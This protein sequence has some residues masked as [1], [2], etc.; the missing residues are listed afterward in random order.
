MIWLWLW[1]ST[2]WANCTI[3]DLEGALDGLDRALSADFRA[4]QPA[5][6]AVE[7][8][9]KCTKETISAMLAARIHHTFAV[10][11]HRTKD[12]EQ[13]AKH[14]VAAWIA[15][16]MSSKHPQ[17][18]IASEAQ[19]RFKQLQESVLADRPTSSLPT[20]TYVDGHPATWAV[21]D[22]PAILQKPGKKPKFVR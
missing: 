12:H 20:L 19:E 8:Q 21:D 16:P 18:P 7:R 11:E 5:T 1:L 13:A 10:L 14:L 9:I 17:M 15:M 4:V 3:A 2:A 6:E 22:L